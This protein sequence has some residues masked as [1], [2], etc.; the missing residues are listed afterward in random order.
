M[1]APGIHRLA[2]NRSARR[3]KGELA[4]AR[5]LLLT[6]LRPDSD[7]EEV[8]QMARATFSGEVALAIEGAE[9]EIPSPSVR[10]CGVCS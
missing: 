10:G 2:R 1:S 3:R 7:R 8:L 9:F 4:R 5:R 6:H